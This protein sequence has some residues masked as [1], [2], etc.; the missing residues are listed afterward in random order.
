MMN[1]IINNSHEHPLKKGKKPNGYSCA[2]C[3]LVI[4][5][6]TLKINVEFPKL[7]KKIKSWKYIRAY[8]PTMWILLFIILIESSIRW[9]HVYYF[10][11]E[12]YLR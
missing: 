8:T 11:L 3:L 12:M 7:L 10:P 4:I 1:R 9:S 2:A 5:L 6:F